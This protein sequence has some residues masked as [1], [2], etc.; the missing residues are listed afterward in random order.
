MDIVIKKP[1][2]EIWISPNKKIAWART[3]KT[4]SS[5]YNAAVYATKWQPIAFDDLDWDNTFVFSHIKEPIRRRHKGVAEWMWQRGIT[6]Q[7]MREH[8]MFAFLEAPFFDFHSLPICLLWQNKIDQIHWIPTDIKKFNHETYT[9][10]M[11]NSFDCELDYEVPEDVRHESSE[12]QIQL[13][14]MIKLHWESS[15]QYSDVV[16]A[17]FQDDVKLYENTILKYAS[18]PEWSNGADCKSVD[19]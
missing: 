16:S 4:G 19:S 11:C 3:Y 14:N 12:E 1:N 13:Y 7:S 17:F 5:F 6:A 9:Q 15:C 10:Q 18:V 8:N 2:R